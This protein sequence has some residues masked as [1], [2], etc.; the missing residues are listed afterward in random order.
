MYPIVD[1]HTHIY[2]EEFDEDFD[3]MLQRAQ[4]AGVY[5]M[6]LPSV[7]S[8]SYGRMI[9]R[10]EAHPDSLRAAIGLHPT[11]VGPDYQQELAFVQEHLSTHR[12]VAIGEIGLDYYWDTTYREAQ[13]EAFARQIGWAGELGLPIIIH[14]RN[15]FADTFA[16]LGAHRLPGQRGVF[17]S[18]TGDETELE[19]ALSFDGFMIG[20]NGVVTFRN[21][22][23]RDY[24]GRIPLDRLLVETDAPYLSPMPHRGRRNEPA[25]LIHTIGHLAP[26]WGLTPGELAEATSANAERLFDLS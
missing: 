21:S 26:L 20:L 4:E 9:R 1:S 19:E 15:A 14:T 22:K 8:H 16:S 11:S 2:A 6:I 17:H 24:V 5:R 7:D 18:F 3:L 13:L 23:L 10:L 25:L 12:W